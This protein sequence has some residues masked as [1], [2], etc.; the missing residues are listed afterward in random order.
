[1]NFEN[2]KGLLIELEQDELFGIDGG[3]ISPPGHPPRN[4]Q[5]SGPLPSIGG[6]GS[7]GSSGC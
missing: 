3:G 1:M 4:N 6:G 7:L 2:L 5:P